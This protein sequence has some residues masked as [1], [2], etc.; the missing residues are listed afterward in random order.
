MEMSAWNERGALAGKLAVWLAVLASGCTMCPGAV[1]CAAPLTWQADLSGL[2]ESDVAGA[3]VHFCRGDECVTLPV[4]PSWQS[5]DGSTWLLSSGL[6]AQDGVHR[7]SVEYVGPT[8]DGETVAIEIVASDGRVLAAR[9]AVI[10]HYDVSE[11]LGPGCGQ[12]A[13]VTLSGVDSATP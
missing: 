1:D 13:G 10:E 3:S 6:N 9:H 4:D 11:P 8:D 5:A 7:A 2:S 12:C